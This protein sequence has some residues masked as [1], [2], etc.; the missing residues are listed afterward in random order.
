MNI[1]DAIE[2][3]AETLRNA[4]VGEPRREAS[5]LLRFVLKKEAIFLIAHRE[6]ELTGEESVRFAEIIARRELREPFQYITGRKDFYGL[7][8]EVS[9][10]VLIP[11]P[12]TE[13]LVEDSIKIAAEIPGPHI[14]EIGVG[15]GCISVSILHNLKNARAVAVDISD[16][17]LALTARNAERHDVSDRLTLRKGDVYEGLEGVF[18]LIVSNPPYI[19]DGH[20]ES[21]QAEVGRFEPH[22]AL[23]GGDDGL[24]IVRC[25][26]DGAPSFLKPCGFILIE[27]GFGQSASVKDMFNA[28]V[29]EDVEFLSDL[30]KISRIAKARL[31]R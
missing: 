30:Q 11:R 22:T 20:L 5:S 6:Y 12:E 24:A 3:A 28:L 29:W 1:S 14:L 25:I 13:I 21:L 31:R 27:I 18:D 2:F 4:G 19:P 8:F 16:D 7:E 26:V 17:A 23:F 10:G 15:S 9:P